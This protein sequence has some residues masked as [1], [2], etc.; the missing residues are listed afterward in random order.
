LNLVPYV[1]Q[2]TD[3]NN[4]RL[5]FAVVKETVLHNNLLDS[6]IIT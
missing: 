1:S 5:A 4:I 6:G 2:A 3:T